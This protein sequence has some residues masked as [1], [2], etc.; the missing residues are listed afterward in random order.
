ML[1]SISRWQVGAVTESVDVTAAGAL[2]QA[3]N[4]S[5][6]TVVEN[7]RRERTSA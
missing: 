3:D 2:L 7:K 5:L 1:R 4:A 6:G